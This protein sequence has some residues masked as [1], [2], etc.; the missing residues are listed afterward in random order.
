MSTWGTTQRT[1]EDRTWTAVVIG[2]LALLLAITVL[3]R[4]A[5]TINVESTITGNVIA[6][7]PES[8]ATT[9]SVP[10]SNR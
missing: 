1:D 6:D 3:D 8:A 7:D 4:A 2:V 10:D 5:D 9:T